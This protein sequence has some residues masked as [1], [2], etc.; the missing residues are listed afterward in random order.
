M[1]E[2]I[3]GALHWEQQGKHGPLMVFAH[4]CPDDHR[5]WLYQM[6]H[7]SAWFRTIGID[8]PGFGRSPD[9]QPGLTLADIAAACWETVDRISDEKVI[10]QGNS[11]GGRV[12]TFM[13]HQ[14]PEQVAAMIISSAGYN[15]TSAF[16]QPMLTAYQEGGIA[17]RRRQ[18]VG[19]FS[20]ATRESPLVEYYIDTITETNR[21]D[22]ESIVETYRALAQP[23]PDAVYD[24][25]WPPTL[26]ITGSLDRNHQTA[27]ALQ[28]RVPGSELATIEGAGHHCNLEQPWE[29]DRHVLDFLARHGFLE[30]RAATGGATASR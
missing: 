7:C 16:A 8:L 21:A 18:L 23:V 15:P 28:A 27:F 20:P 25:I 3:P 17:M 22:A 12:V 2:H 19:H 29:F 1:A 14:R 4:A 13:R 11:L 6:A 5:F 10:L 24:G 9:P 30:R 26:I